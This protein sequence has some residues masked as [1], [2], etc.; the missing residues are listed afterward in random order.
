[1][2]YWIIRAHKLPASPAGSS[3]RSNQFSL[4][5]TGKNASGR[6]I[7]LAFGCAVVLL[8]RCNV[9]GAIDSACRDE[10]ARSTNVL[11]AQLDLEHRS[12]KPEV[13]G[14]IPPQYITGRI[15]LYLQYLECLVL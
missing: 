6:Q 5:Y 13:G 2:I 14:S 11:V 12:T 1:M 15:W 3:S 10:T 4:F 7:A 8:W 9:S